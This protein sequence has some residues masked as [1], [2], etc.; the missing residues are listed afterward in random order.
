MEVTTWPEA[1]RCKGPRSGPGDHAGRNA[2]ERCAGLETEVAEAD[3][4]EG[5]GRLPSS[6][7]RT[8]RAPDGSAGVVAA[9]RMEE[10]S[11]GNTGS[12]VGGGHA[13][14][15][16]PRGAGWAGRVAERPVRLKT[17][18]NAGRGKGPQVWKGALKGEGLGTMAV[19]TTP[20][21]V[22]DPGGI[23]CISEGAVTCGRY[24]TGEASTGLPVG[25]GGE[26]CERARACIPCGTI[27]C[28]PIP[29]PPVVAGVACVRDA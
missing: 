8:T 28:D 24:S 9:A 17:P 25:P 3:L 5:W 14:T 22:S 19:P 6:G 10:G 29:P 18:G 20:I 27:G 12:P 23:T 7:K 1:L 2:S 11:V 21:T 13:P 15:G 16:P 26:R 4:P